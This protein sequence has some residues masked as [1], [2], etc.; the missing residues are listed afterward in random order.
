V[1][2]D[3][4]LHAP[5]GL[6][7][8]D[9]LALAYLSQ[10]A[11]V[12][13]ISTTHGNTLARWAC[14]AAKKSV[15]EIVFKRS[16]GSL[17]GR[18]GKIE[19]GDGEDGPESVHQIKR[20]LAK[21]T[22]QPVVHCGGGF[23]GSPYPYG[24][25]SLQFMSP[26]ATLL[27]LGALTNVAAA[28]KLGARPKRIVFMGGRFEANGDSLLELNILA[29][30]TACQQVIDA[31]VEKIV[32]P[33]NLLREIVITP[34]EVNTFF[35]DSWAEKYRDV[36]HRHATFFAKWNSWLFG[37]PSSSPKGFHPWVG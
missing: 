14:A 1:D 11:V 28:L 7:I 33:I 21:L 22:E 26:G 29:D 3:P 34:D 9:D 6:D 32:L 16:E 25:K 36:F 24:A 27:A 8:D 12:S 18:T 31:N 13:S 20:A 2:L 4:A 37:T 23:I 19:G 17:S 5:F 30:G 35:L 15:D 10:S